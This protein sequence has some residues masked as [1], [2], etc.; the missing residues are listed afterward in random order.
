M[1][2]SKSRYAAMAS[3]PGSCPRSHS[4]FLDLY[5]IAATGFVCGN[6]SATML[7]ALEDRLEN[8]H[9]LQESAGV[10]E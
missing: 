9:L 4:G 8:W 2:A 7:A 1:A 10:P 3:I 5:L 6:P